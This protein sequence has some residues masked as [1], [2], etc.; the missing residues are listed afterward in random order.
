MI[1]YQRGAVLIVS[2]MMLAALTLIGVSAMNTSQMSQKMAAN[3]QQ[4]FVVFGN[5]ES[6][7]ETLLADYSASN[8]DGKKTIHDDCAAGKVAA[9]I[10]STPPGYE[11]P[12][13][14]CSAACAPAS[15]Q[16]PDAPSSSRFKLAMLDVQGTSRSSGGR[17]ET[18][19]HAGIAEMVD[20]TSGLCP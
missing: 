6:A 7:V 20:A 4:G 10:V 9:V 14:R 12:V 3:S 19:I 15:I 1:D 11:P 18:T 17:H 13:V 5:A 8:V 2:M 16:N